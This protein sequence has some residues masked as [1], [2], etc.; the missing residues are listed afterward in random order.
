M[1]GGICILYV[2][3]DADRRTSTASALDDA[4][5]RFTVTT[6]PRTTDALDRLRED[7]DSIDCLVSEYDLPET[8]GLTFLERIRDH[9]SKLPFVVFTGDG[10]ERLASAAFG[11][12]ATD[13]LS[14]EFD[15]AYDRLSTRIADAVAEFREARTQERDRRLFRRAIEASGHSV[16]FTERDGTIQYVNSAFEEATGYTAAEARGQTPQILKSGVHDRAFY[17]DLWD[18]I[19]DG[20]VWRNE[21]VNKRRSGERYVVDQTIAPVKNGCGEVEWFV[22]VNADITERKEHKEELER[23][24]ERLRALLENSPDAIVVHAPDGTVVDLNRQT[25][26][27]LGYDREQLLTMNVADFEVEKDVEELRSMWQGM[28]TGE[29][30]EIE[31]RHR[32][33]DGS[34][35]PVEVWITKVELEGATRFIAFSRDAT[36]RHEY[37]QELQRQIDR[38]EQ[39]ATVVSHDLRNPLN[40]ASGRLDLL[41][42]R[43]D[44]EHLDVATDALDRMAE[45]IEDLLILAREGGQATDREPIDLGAMI[46]QCWQMIA[47]ADA[48]LEVDIEREI[49][50]DRPR[51][52]QLLE[53]LVRN[54]IEHGGDSVT[55]R[56]GELDDG[57]YVADDGPGIPPEERDHVFETG[58]SSDEDGT[59]L[60]LNIVR[61]IAEAHGWDVRVVES[62]HGGA[63]FE[64]LGVETA[65]VASGEAV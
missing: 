29:R 14:R 9:R 43:V 45:L 38:L 17:E 34:T 52:K 32:R 56:I 48:S 59:G 54:A 35:Y 10:S 5:Q 13:Y 50:A 6:E 4:D 28:E 25:V 23:S 46:D 11:A 44:S 18:T 41:D 62:D 47:T 19:L 33:A 58:Y 27:D 3:G 65:T 57:F 40:V 53:N 24:R 55:V 7:P 63:R 61:Q 31:G 20:D 22:A 2:D 64:F 15:D 21:I 51:L 30:V 37:E 12:G 49:A 1:T 42:Q 16:Y 60:G 8:D 36:E 26:D 39:F